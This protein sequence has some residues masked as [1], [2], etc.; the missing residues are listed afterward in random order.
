MGLF[1][2]SVGLGIIVTAF[3]GLFAKN[4]TEPT[5][6]AIVK[7]RLTACLRVLIHV[8]P[9]GVAFVEI[10]INWNG[11]YLGDSFDKQTYL[12][13]VAKAHE[14][15]LQASLAA[16]LL[17][18]LRYEVTRESGIPFGGL[19][20]GIQF[21]QISY[22][23]SAEFWSC[24]IS[25][26]FRIWRKV[27]FS[28][29]TAI[30]AL[31]AATVG[32]SSANLLVP[33][34]SGWPS[35]TASLSV[36]A[37]FEDIWPDR[38]TG[39]PIADVCA[40]FTN[41]TAWEKLNCPAFSPASYLSRKLNWVTD[42][43]KSPENLE[44]AKIRV[45]YKNRDATV[46]ISSSAPCEITGRGQYCGTMP[47][48]SLS[49]YLSSTFRNTEFTTSALD[50]YGVIQRDYYQ[51]YVMASCAGKFLEQSSRDSILDFPLLSETESDPSEDR[52]VLP[53]PG[54]TVEQAL[55]A[56]GNSSQHSL[57]WVDLPFED[58]NTRVPG[59][60]IVHPRG[61]IGLANITTCT[62]AAGWGSSKI[63][64]RQAG[65]NTVYSNNVGTPDS[66]HSQDQPRDQYNFVMEGVPRFANESGFLFPQYRIEISKDWAEF[67]NP[68]VQTSSGHNSSLIDR[69]LSAVLGVPPETLIARIICH[70][71]SV[72]LSVGLAEYSA[73]SMVDGSMDH[74]IQDS[75]TN[76][77]KV[78]SRIRSSTI[79]ASTLQLAMTT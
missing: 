3:Q 53:V 40:F 42:V 60:V 10:I 63:I 67:L 20:G 39:Q 16:A 36:N 1:L 4:F 5:K 9:M 28:A 30:S 56:H 11:R 24:L 37:R 43:Y 6:A 59:I 52:A 79:T 58:F 31:L 27:L 66:W 7:S 8:I 17:T 19:L 50:Q 32:P 46:R 71:F 33:R 61:S 22:L 76:S 41:S 45:E 69:M 38:L 49:R 68:Q 44:K 15:T 2:R 70:F 25:R 47:V 57:S 12:Q 62:V 29:A 48:E 13:F 23:W 14:I 51:P 34:Q 74:A 78:L 26:D 72:G 35:G 21:L 18:Y 75:V 65:P 64:R 73:K 54:S 55:N 77:L